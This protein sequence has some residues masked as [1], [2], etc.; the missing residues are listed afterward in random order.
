[1]VN[2]K[3]A[4]IRNFWI[5]A[6]IDGCKGTI[7]K[8]PKN[9]DGGIEIVIYMRNKKTVE[10]MLKITGK[11][12]PDNRLILFIQNVDEKINK[13]SSRMDFTIETER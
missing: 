12:A 5:D 4:S 10:K 11:V 9:K 1:M 7:S 3:P 13:N 6:T 8:G 2:R